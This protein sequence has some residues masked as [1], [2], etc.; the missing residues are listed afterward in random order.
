MLE[1]YKCE[2]RIQHTCGL[3]LGDII[4]RGLVYRRFGL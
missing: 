4:A 3:Y 1:I 2:I